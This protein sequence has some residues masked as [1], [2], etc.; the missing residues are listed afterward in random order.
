MVAPEKGRGV[1]KEGNPRG[2]ASDSVSCHV[3]NYIIIR[4]LLS[5]AKTEEKD[6][7]PGTV[8]ILQLSSDHYVTPETNTNRDFHS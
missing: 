4:L 2:V 7:L 5:L 6:Y 8:V 3:H 1:A